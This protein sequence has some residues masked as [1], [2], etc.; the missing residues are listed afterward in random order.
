MITKEKIQIDNKT[1]EKTEV[2]YNKDYR[3]T[4]VL[5]EEL[6]KNPTLSLKAACRLSAKYYKEDKTYKLIC[7]THCVQKRKEDTYSMELHG[8]REDLYLCLKTQQVKRLS[9]KSFLDFFNEGVDSF[10]E[11]SILKA[12]EHSKQL[13]IK[14]N[15]GNNN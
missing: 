4:W 7:T 3:M 8:L 2:D 14:K 13:I 1:F 9:S 11:E 6:S 15:K 12:I 5:E 10:S